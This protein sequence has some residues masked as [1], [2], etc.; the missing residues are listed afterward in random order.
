METTLEKTNVSAEML[1]DVL[2]GLQQPQKTLPSKYFYDQKGS[3]LFEQITEL[4]EY[5]LTRTE[6]QIMQG[7]IQKIANS[8][9]EKIQLVELGSGS[10]FKTRLLLNHLEQIH[11][12][13]PVD[14][15]KNFLDE[16]A[17]NLRVEFPDLKINPVAT[18]Y[19]RSLELPETP[20]GVN[21]IIYFPG[22]T[23]GNFTKEHAEE[24]I[25]LIANSIHQNGGLLIGFD[26]VKD[27]EALLAAYD[28]SEG[29]TAQFNK[30]I[31]RRINRE[32][33][34]DF[35]LHQFDHQA[36]FNE[37]KSRIEM[38]LVSKSVQ[39]VHI[40]GEE[41][42]FEKGETIHTENSHK[43]TL[44]SFREMTKPYFEHVITWTDA[45][46]YFAVQYLKN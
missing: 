32:L 14:I 10:S 43:Y 39:V 29:V 41:I 18:D 8:L 4:D 36:I 9:G 3:E 21:R 40:I 26:L 45:N 28:D 1:S 25:G 33:G 42:S 38:Y 37:D 35:D 34:A 24:F 23:I 27:R 5:Y 46:D 19:T 31:L 12:Y 13:V 22:S 44:S 30:N 16:V 11:S 6:L 7:N 17:E 15:S 2:E 20:D